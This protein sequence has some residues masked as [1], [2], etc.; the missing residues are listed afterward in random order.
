MRKQIEDIKHIYQLKIRSDIILYSLWNI[1]LMKSDMMQMLDENIHEAF[2]WQ[3]LLIIN[4]SI[5]T[6]KKIILTLKTFLT[7]FINS[8]YW[9]F[10]RMMMIM[11]NN[12]VH[13]DERITQIIKTKKH[14]I[15]FLS[16][17]LSD[18]N[19]IELIFSVLKAWIKYHYHFMRQF[20]L[21]FDDFL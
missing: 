12:S 13:V 17:Y 10:E 18:F 8:F 14:L 3:W 2:A 5:Q 15:C 11:N 19:S 16:F 6:L 7:D 1:N 9:H 4:Y 20:C 21:N